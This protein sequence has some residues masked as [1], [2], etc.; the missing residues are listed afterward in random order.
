MSKVYFARPLTLFGPSIRL[1][2]LLRIFGSCGGSGHAYFFAFSVGPCGCCAAGVCG[3]CGLAMGHLHALAAGLERGLADAAERAAS[4]DVAV[5]LAIDLRDGRLR[6][7]LEQRHGGHHEP[8]RAEAAH[9][10]VLIA[11]R[12]LYG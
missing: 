7:L 6:I 4:A 8:G 9:H 10:R 11:E 3:F 5:Q 2:W 12:L 1:T